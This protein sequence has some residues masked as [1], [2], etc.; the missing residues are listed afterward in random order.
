MPVLLIKQ[1]FSEIVEKDA[2]LLVQTAARLIELQVVEKVKNSFGLS[3][4]IPDQYVNLA[5]KV[6]GV[7]LYDEH[8]KK[9]V[10]CIR[11]EQDVQSTLV[12]LNGLSAPVVYFVTDTAGKIVATSEVAGIGETLSGI[13]TVQ[14]TNKV[15]KTKYKGHSVYAYA[16]VNPVYGFYTISCV[17]TKDIFWQLLF[18]VFL[19]ICIALTVLLIIFQDYYRTKLLSIAESL[20][21]LSEGSTDVRIKDRRISKIVDQLSE[22]I[23]RKDR[24]LRKTAQELENLKQTLEKIREKKS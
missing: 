17:Q 18:P 16:A 14:E 7:F 22:N 5:K 10:V 1:R 2:V 8:L 21:K 13:I 9:V 24:I 4:Q 11:K 3:D 19:C 23:Q 12:S 15:F 6:G 20:E